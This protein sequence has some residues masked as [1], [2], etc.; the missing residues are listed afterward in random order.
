[1]KKVKKKETPEKL[2]LNSYK[3]VVFSEK[4][5]KLLEE[6][7]Q[8]EVVRWKQTHFGKRKTTIST[9][10]I[11]K[12]RSKPLY[13]LPGG[14]LQRIREKLKEEGIPYIIE[15]N[16]HK[17]FSAK[18]VPLNGITL[19]GNQ[20]E[21]VEKALSVNRGVIHAYTSFGKT[22]TAAALIN[23]YLTAYPNCRAIFLVHTVDLIEQTAEEFRKVLPFK[24][25]IWKGKDRGDYQVV[26][27][28][29]QTLGRME[30]SDYSGKFLI[31]IRDECHHSGDEY[32]KLLYNL[33]CPVRYGITATLPNTKI[34][35][36]RL[37]GSVGPVIGTVTIAEG[38]EMGLLAVPEVNLMAYDNEAV[39]EARTYS[40][41]YSDLITENV[42][43]NLSI[44]WL[45][46]YLAE[47]GESSLIFVREIE[48][49]E[50]LL[51][52]FPKGD[53][54]LVNGQTPKETRIKIKKSLED[55]KIK[56]V[57]CSTVW[58]EGISIKSLNNCIVAAGGKDEKMV[59]QIVGRGTRIDEGKDTVRIWDFLDPQKYMS[60]HSIERIGVYAKN[61]WKINII[62]HNNIEEYVKSL[63][64][65]NE[66][67]TRSVSG[68]RKASWTNCKKDS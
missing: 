58:N 42:N 51:K 56:I 5:K 8:Y 37:E 36:L 63:G 48:H 57:I 18:M 39:T 11:G 10:Y 52:M 17:K 7:F 33:N 62:H 34:E 67:T 6:F 31:V 60:G 32:Q 15:E 65:K 12:L 25:G 13:H 46:H 26:C 40:G 19:R 45:A 61:K 9:S 44:N 22:V 68:K 21:I 47:I 66:G 64:V 4:V 53:A 24:V 54:Y 3:Q 2:L 23:A 29:R 16:K 59:M 50:T 43:R 35:S 55:K 49:G 41:A 14:F 20:P 1:M 38:A 27:V 28:T 30:E